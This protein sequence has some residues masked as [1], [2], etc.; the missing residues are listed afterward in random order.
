[1]F[2]DLRKHLWKMVRNFEPNWQLAL[3]LATVA[4]E[5]A[6]QGLG[7]RVGAARLFF[8]VSPSPRMTLVVVLVTVVAVATPIKIWNSARIE[9]RLQ[10]QAQLLLAAKIEG[11]KST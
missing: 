9:H 2:I 11:L 1:V 6:R 10:E 7:T 5:L 4:L 8:L 3:L